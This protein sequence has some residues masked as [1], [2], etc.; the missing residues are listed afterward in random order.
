MVIEAMKPT[1]GDNSSQCCNKLDDWSYLPEPTNKQIL[2]SLHLL[3]EKID[4]LLKEKE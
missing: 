3:H 1:N 2:K 4:K